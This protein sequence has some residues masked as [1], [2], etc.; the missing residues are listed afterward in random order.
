MRFLVKVRLVDTNTYEGTPWYFRGVDED[1][2]EIR[3]TS[4][5]KLAKK[6]NSWS[7]A[8]IAN[9]LKRVIE[10]TERKGVSELYTFEIGPVNNY[11]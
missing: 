3:W 2:G 9:T 11:W 8:E 1:S 10:W 7:K 6:Y 4:S 5:A